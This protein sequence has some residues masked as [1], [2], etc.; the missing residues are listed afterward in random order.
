MIRGGMSASSPEQASRG[1][2]WT[3]RL[4]SGTIQQDHATIAS[5]TIS[6][7]REHRKDRSMTLETLR[8][9]FG[10]CTLINWGFLLVWW[11]FFWLGH[12]LVYAIHHTWFKLSRESFDTIH[13]AVMAAY[14]TA[15]FLF[16]LVP[17][18]ALHIIG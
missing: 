8:A 17:Y 4:G 7:A 10:C 15:I 11:L 1:V 6:A 14:K 18:L 13:Y 5:V 16:C 2:R 9:F 12:D 3:Q